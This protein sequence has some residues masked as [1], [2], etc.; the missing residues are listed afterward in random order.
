MESGAVLPSSK[1]LQMIL[2][3]NPP[4]AFL[5]GWAVMVVAMMFPVLIAPICH[6]RL[7]SFTHRRGRAVALFLSAY[8]AFWMALG[9]V[10]LAIRLATTV[11]LPQSYLPMAG[12]AI[13]ALVWQ[14]SPLKQRCLNGCH[15]PTELPAFG[16]EADFAALRFGLS[17]AIWCGGSCWALMLLPMLLPRWHVLAMAAMTVLI[18]SEKLE[19]PRPPGWR[20][21]GLSKAARI[22]TAQARIHVPRLILEV[23]TKQRRV[24]SQF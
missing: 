1:S 24:L 22:V 12:V 19:Q 11:F 18:F 16:A 13:M 5:T 7:R 6:I 8:V 3:M 21:R 15:A 20:W 17:H 4:G 10:L 9:S 23:E 14:A 2:A